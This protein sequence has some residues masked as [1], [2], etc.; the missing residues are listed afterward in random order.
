MV[1]QMFLDAYTYF[2]FKI[3]NSYYIKIV[4][5]ILLTDHFALFKKEILQMKSNILLIKQALNGLT[6]AQYSFITINIGYTVQVLLHIVLIDLGKVGIP[7]I[8]SL[9][10]WT[11]MS[12]FSLGF[13]SGQSSPKQK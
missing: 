5:L 7:G 9:Q 11:I 4:Y 6:M 2:R 12:F 3:Y 1:Y 10:T 8:T 13:L